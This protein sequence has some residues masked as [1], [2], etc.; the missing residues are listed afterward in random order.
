MPPRLK[1]YFLCV[2]VRRKPSILVWVER[3][4]ER[5]RERINH[6]GYVIV[7]DSSV[8]YVVFDLKRVSTCH[9]DFQAL[10]QI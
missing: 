7:Y 6:G 10:K 5:E 1:L 3:E 2:S 8:R 4:T 9:E